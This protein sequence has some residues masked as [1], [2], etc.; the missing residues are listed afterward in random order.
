MKYAAN[1]G[2]N[3]YASGRQV[4]QFSPPENIRK[5][6]EEAWESEAG[7]KF[8]AEMAAEFRFDKTRG[9]N[10]YDS[11]YRQQTLDK[12]GIS[13]KE[14]NVEKG[15]F[16]KAVNFYKNLQADSGHW[17]GDYGGPLFLTPGLVIAA[18]VTETKLPAQHVALIKQYMLNHQNTD[19]GWGLHIEGPS[20]MFGTVL[21]YVS[22]RILGMRESED[23]IERARLWIKRNGG[24]TAVPLWG[25]FYL[26]LLGIYE[27]VGINSLLPELWLLPR[28]LPVHPANYWCHARMVYLPM[29]YCYGKKIKANPSALL[30]ELKNELYLGPY[31]YVDWKAARNNCAVADLYYPQSPFLKVFNKVLNMYEQR[32][33]NALRKK[34]NDFALSYINAEDEQSNFIDIGPVNQA[35]NSVCVWYAYGK[36]DERFKK[37]VE[38][39]FDYLWLAE[40][41][42]KMNG[43][44]GSQLWD[45]A[46]AAQ[47]IMEGGAED[48]TETLQKAN[49]FI[50]DAQVK[51]EVKDHKKF[52]RHDSVGGWPFSTNEHGWPI[53]DCTAEGLKTVLLFRES[54]VVKMEEQVT[55]N[56][57]K[58]SADLILTFQNPNGGWASYELTRG[59]RWL[60]ALNPS[61]VFGNIMIDYGY[62]ECSSTCIQSLMKFRIAF[63]D[64]RKQE[65]ERAITEGINFILQQQCE[66]GSW[67]GSWAV[68]FTYGTWFAV[69]AL[70]QALKS[71]MEFTQRVKMKHA[72][73]K[74]ASFL[75]SRQMADGGWGECF[76]S[77]I[78]KKYVQ[79]KTSQVIN[80][81]WAL[82]SLMAMDFADKAVIDKGI[83]LLKLR[84]L[85]DG[86]FAQEG[87]SGVF[88]HNC[89]ITY[90]SYRNV[91]PI[92]ALGRYERIY[93]VG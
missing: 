26:A 38:R 45:T 46:F 15:A 24:A 6:G 61:E 73:A 13:E 29:A 80:T 40:D 92:W 87:V 35:I 8:L 34:A 66:D 67:Y 43:Y 31:E 54:G 65:I 78:N 81:A 51:E 7:Q 48:F 20:T 69:E 16:H 77:C 27:W 62:T 91:F 1:W 17:P 88:N 84:Q 60:E 21:Q 57:L 76:E 64:Y 23:L 41:G 68:C 79:H 36:D 25:K 70:S 28:S 3:T 30:D 53:T 39:W 37:H 56:M 58:K 74:A 75:V 72:L 85:A 12:S 14:Q 2:L 83:E 63:P 86:D 59:P 18:Y 19:G 50:V 47:A 44:N 5:F 9:A 52:Y 42:M 10:S 4:W 90:T 82:L 55:D 71:N 32:P 33:V 93:K 11:I 89:A 22:L 49:R